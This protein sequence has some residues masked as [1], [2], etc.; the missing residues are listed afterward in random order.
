MKGR[1]Q[2]RTRTVVLVNALD[3]PVAQ[4]DDSTF[5]GK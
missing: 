2:E 1:P 3:N 4:I 5:Q